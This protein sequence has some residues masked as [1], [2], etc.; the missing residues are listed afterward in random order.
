MKNGT[1]MVFLHTTLAVWSILLWQQAAAGSPLWSEGNPQSFA[2]GDPVELKFKKLTSTETLFP[3]DPGTMPFCV[4]AG[5]PKM[6]RQ[7]LGEALAGDRIQSSPYKLQMKVDT[8]CEQLCVWHFGRA[9]KIGV[10]PSKVVKAIRKNYHSNWLVDNLPAASLTETDTYLITRYSQGI[11][12]GFIAED[13]KLA[14][15]YNHV[16]IQLMYHPVNEEPG[17]YRVVRFIVQPFFIAHEFEELAPGGDHDFADDAYLSPKVVKIGN[18][19]DSCKP[20]GREHTDYDM[21]TARGREPQL[22][23]GKILFTYDVIW[24]EKKDLAWTSRWDIYLTMDNAVPARVHWVSIRNSHNYVFLLTAFVAAILIRNLKRD[25]GQYNRL[26]S[27]V[28]GEGTEEWHG[29]KAVHGDIFRPPTFCGW[30][31]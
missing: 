12:I 8:Y 29:W 19:I 27:T 20:G 21:V 28:G 22:A 16:N 30:P 6:D 7:N 2:S 31:S 11:P 18:P 1:I 14:Y 4:P 25:Q 26:A 24:I 23:S 15:I 5:G 13:T 17:M 3:L 10:G 9:E